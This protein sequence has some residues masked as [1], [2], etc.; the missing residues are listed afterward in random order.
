[1]FAQLFVQS[2]RFGSTVISVRTV[3]S[4]PSQNALVVINW[5]QIAGTESRVDTTLTGEPIPINRERL[6][7]S[8][9][10]IFQQLKMLKIEN[11]IKSVFIFTTVVSFYGDGYIHLRTVEASVHTLLHMRFRTSSRAGL[12]FL[13]A[14]H[15]DFLLLE[16][17]SGYLQVN[18][19]TQRVAL[20]IIWDLAIWT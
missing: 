2:E 13:A 15:R 10:S 19:K 6:S 4:D 16:L 7:S 3:H 8:W 20:S 5:I 11:V 9:L 18:T 17:I 14:G 1:M 12:L